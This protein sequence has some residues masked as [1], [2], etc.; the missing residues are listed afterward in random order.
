MGAS[1]QAAG[2]GKTGVAA[3][4]SGRTPTR[5]MY[6]RGG[7][8]NCAKN[9]VSTLRWA[10]ELKW[11][12]FSS[13]VVCLWFIGLI[14][15]DIELPK[16]KVSSQPNHVC[17]VA[18]P[19]SPLDTPRCPR[20][21]QHCWIWT[22]FPTLFP[23]PNLCS[24]AIACSHGTNGRCHLDENRTPSCNSTHPPH[25]QALRYGSPRQTPVYLASHTY[26]GLCEARL[27]RL[28]VAKHSV[29]EFTEILYTH[30][31][32]IYRSHC[33]TQHPYPPTGRTGTTSVSENPDEPLLHS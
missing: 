5:T 31:T 1:E 4:E 7:E 28:L 15:L 19:S 9:E 10:G 27:P 23:T 33:I 32:P 2:R 20:E 30:S 17:F 21:S 16:I 18:S 8:R 26:G 3:G 12:V 25:P 6:S 14:G 29:T 24:L 13:Q 22:L 11:K